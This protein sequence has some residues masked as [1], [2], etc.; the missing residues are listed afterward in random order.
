MTTRGVS[1][2]A[3]LKLGLAF[4]EERPHPLT[5]LIA[6]EHQAKCALLERVRGA[7]VRILTLLDHLSCR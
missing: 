7:D 4:L 5:V 1:A 6:G 3:S 2:L